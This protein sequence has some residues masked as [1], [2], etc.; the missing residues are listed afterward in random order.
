MLNRPSALKVALGLER[1]RLPSFGKGLAPDGRERPIPDT[2]SC[3]PA[4]PANP[5]PAARE[6]I[7]SCYR[8]GERLLARLALHRECGND[9]GIAAALGRIAA[10]RREATRHAAAAADVLYREV[11]ESAESVGDPGKQGI[12]L[13]RLGALQRQ[14]DQLGAALDA[15]RRAL[16]L[17]RESGKTES[18][19]RT[20]ELLA[21]GERRLGHWDAAEIWYG[22]TLAL[23][24]ALGDRT[25]SGLTGARL[26]RLMQARAEATDDPYERQRLLVEALAEVQASLRIWQQTNNFVY[27]AVSHRRLAILYRLLGNRERVESHARQALAVFEPLDHPQT[28]KVYANLVEIART[29]GDRSAAEAWQAQVDLKRAGLERRAAGCGS[30]HAGA[31]PKLSAARQALARAVRQDRRSATAAGSDAGEVLTELA[32]LPAPLGDLGIFLRAVARGDTPQAPPICRSRRTGSPKPYSRPYAKRLPDPDRSSGE[33]LARR[34]SRWTLDV[35]TPGNPL[36]RS[37]RRPYQ[38]GGI[39]NRD[40]QSPGFPPIIARFA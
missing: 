22:N 10:V 5:N 7:L 36:A 40:D 19:M 3:A 15:H 17:F 12:A 37:V 32:G 18:E 24:E 35:G 21:A 11:L 4:A 31:T 27:G 26:G 29:C 9:R 13:E 25:Q 16:R 23:A 30:D 6:Y 28:W 1:R 2:A 8:D 34:R 20:C 14:T 33:S 38:T 39:D